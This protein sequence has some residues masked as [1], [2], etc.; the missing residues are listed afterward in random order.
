MA[1][2]E[3]KVQTKIIKYL[4]SKK[5]YVIKTKPGPGTPLG[6][7]DIIFFYE[8]FWG[9]I[10]CKAFSTSPFRTLQKETLDKFSTWSWSAV[11][12]SENVDDVI[13]ELDDIL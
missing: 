12:H 2:V 9:A 7:P 6:C 5:C 10:E 4:K 3:S 1:S 8:G 11:A 13:A